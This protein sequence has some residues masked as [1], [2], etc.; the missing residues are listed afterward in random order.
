M[1]FNKLLTITF[2]TSVVFIL[3]MFYIQPFVS[4]YISLVAMYCFVGFVIF[5][6]TMFVMVKY[7]PEIVAK[8]LNK[9]N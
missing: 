5:S 4:Q 3:I 7:A 8:E 9:E 1:S 2:I 6:A